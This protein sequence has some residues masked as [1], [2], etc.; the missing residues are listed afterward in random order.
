[1]SKK[2]VIIYVPGLGDVDLS[3]RRRALGLWK[4]RAVKPVV[5]GVDWSTAE[6]WQQKL[7]RLNTFIRQTAQPNTAIVLVGESAGAAAVT[8]AFADNPSI[9]AGVVLLC[10]KSQFPELLGSSYTS[11][12][13]ALKDAVTASATV[14]QGLTAQQRAKILNLHPLFDPIVPVRETKIP[15]TKNSVIPM[16]GH[17]ASIAFVITL[18]SWRIVIHAR[19]CSKS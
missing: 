3:M 4:Y 17:A 19:K 16:V 8:Q 10:G 9:V 15:G 6:P 7:H 5:F 13:P 11:R 12:H 18:W 1:M 14:T 2:T